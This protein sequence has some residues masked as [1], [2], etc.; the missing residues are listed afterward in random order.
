MARDVH[1]ISRRDDA[2]AWS[3]VAS[4]CRQGRLTTVVLTGEA[5]RETA[6]SIADLLPGLGAE[7]APVVVALG[8]HLGSPGGGESWE[9]TDYLGAVD[10][11]AHSAAAVAW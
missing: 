8:P 3:A 10:L 6:S 1:I 11:L 5:V 2:R 9:R 4:S 7:A